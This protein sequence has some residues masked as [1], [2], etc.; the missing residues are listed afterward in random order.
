VSTLAD[1]TG[2]AVERWA[3]LVL[4]WPRITILVVVALAAFCIVYTADHLGINTDTA[5]MISADLPWRQ[6]FIRYRESF[7]SRDRNIVAVVDADNPAAAAD[8]AS[9]VAAELRAQPEL[10]PSVF[11]AGDGAFFAQNG[12][13]YLGVDELDE[14]ASRLEEAQ[15][16]LGLMSERGNG[17]GVISVIDRSLTPDPSESVEPAGLD[18]LYLEA[19]RVLRAAAEGDPSPFDWGGLLGK[20]LDTGSRPLILVRPSLDFA[21]IRPARPAIERMREVAGRLATEMAGNPRLRLTGTLAMEDEELQTVVRGASFA[22]YAALV[23][24]GLVL[25]FFL[26]S[27]RLLAISLFT[28]VTGL[29]GTAAFAAAFVGQLNL[30]S[31]AFAVLYV[32]LGVDFILHVTLRV[33]ELA[34][35]GSPADEAVLV[36]MRG[37]GASLVICAVTTAAGFY[38]FI[39][40]PFEGVSELGLIS[41]TG[42][43]VSL[44]VSVTLLPALITQLAARTL[45]D[46]AARRSDARWTVAL[47]RHP[48]VVTAVCVIG[49]VISA[50]LLPNVSF[51]SNPIHLR[52][53][54]SESIVALEELAEDSDSAV[55]SLVAL[56]DSADAARRWADE[57]EGLPEVRAVNT[58][59]S[60]VPNAQMEKLFI[61]DDLR[62]VL[63]PGFERIERPPAD[64]AAL[65]SELESL[66][67]ALTRTGEKTVA[68]SELLGA[69]RAL[70]ASMPD[71]DTLRHLDDDLIGNL[72]L[73]LERLALALSAAPFDETRLPPELVERWTSGDAVLIEI[74]P[75]ENINDN[76]AAARFI[77]AV[78][79]RVPSATGLPIVHQ[80][81]SATVV[82]SFRL[83]LT[84]AFILVIVL[85]LLFLRSIRDT[86]LII[87]P[88]AFAA[89]VTAAATVLLGMPFNF[90]NIIALPL[91]VGVG[92]DSGIH[93]L[94]RMRTEPPSAG[95]SRTSTSRA[96]LAS[97][98]TTIASFGN[99]AFSAHV[100]MSS[101]GIL[102]TLGM[103]VTLF[104]TL[105]FLPALLRST[106]PPAGVGR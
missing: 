9:R 14:L 25:Y 105:V 75:E 88:I 102:L 67:D 32:G 66:V 97:G 2:A 1:I 47:A 54:E 22:G 17:A 57:L 52:D 95:Q 36:T 63:G 21:E 59:E 15:P 42:M 58:I 80:E 23:M 87:I 93:I 28:L 99:L 86:V 56:A 18:D 33:K 16:L 103:A 40:T 20:A 13:L 92:V 70:L 55:L 74:L 83:A 7:P 45:G 69:S 41:G 65:R 82:R 91:L 101:M 90:A 81:A 51:D 73:E 98:L 72:S 76:D 79:S 4:K 84:Y 35:E 64:A 24:V 49:A 89:I 68:E 46:P 3:R 71:A 62:L 53:P 27:I 38:S 48:R 50:L 85:T 77:A 30:L 6:D 37:V 106:A 8:F 100:G 26:R 34:A 39:P 31:V 29:T 19:A 104:A 96:V 10:F 44:F 94:H 43:F 60:L 11:L 5:D 78:R 61:I 12:L